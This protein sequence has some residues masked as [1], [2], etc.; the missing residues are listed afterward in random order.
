MAKDRFCNNMEGIVTAKGERAKYLGPGRDNR[1]INSDF[2]YLHLKTYQQ[3][4]DKFQE[5][6]PRVQDLMRGFAKGFNHS[7]SQNEHYAG[8]CE[9]LVQD[10]DHIDVFAQTL[11]IN[12]WAFMAHY[13]QYIGSA[14]PTSSVSAKALTTQQKTIKPQIKGSNGWALGKAMTETGK[15][16]ILSNTHLEHGGKNAWY[17]AH[18]TIPGEM[19]VYGG[20][21]PGFMTPALGFND[22]F[23]WTHTWTKA[24]PGSLYELT[25]SPHS[26]LAYVYGDDFRVLEF[27]EYQIDVKQADGSITPLSR[28]LYR[29]HYGPIATFEDGMIAVKDAPSQKHNYSDYWLKLALSKNVDE[30]VDLNRQGYRTGSQNIMMADSRGETFYADLASVPNLSAEAW[31]LIAKT[32]ELDA[33]NGGRLNG[34]DPVFEWSDVV[35]FDEVPKGRSEHYV[36]NANEAAWLMNLQQPLTGYS[37]LYGGSEYLQSPRTRL[38]VAMLEELKNSGKKVTLQDLQYAMDHK[39]IYQAELVLDDLVARCQAYPNVLV[40]DINVDLAPACEVLAKWD[41]TANLNSVGMH[42]FREYAFQVAI[43]GFYFGCT[44]WCWET[45]FD[46]K[47]PVETPSGLPPVVDVDQDFHLIS[48]ARAVLITA[49]LGLDV[50][51]PVSDVQYLIKGDRKHPIAGG[52]GDISGSFS[53]MAVVGDENIDYLSQ[54]GLTQAGYGIDNGD[55]FIYVSEF[56][57]DGINAR[58][59]LLYSQ[60]NNPASK[61][62]FDQ[63]ELIEGGKYKPVLFK[64]KDITADNNY[65]METLE[66]K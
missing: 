12:Y 25:P 53:T 19:D 14:E 10:I 24:N 31:S 17:E 15:G 51:S 48:L 6:D 32:P 1:N 22:H 45:T 2:A 52:Y 39:R 60:S 42:I 13:I 26:N 35:P 47:K 21:L 30:A 61:H 3:A 33:E 49:Q 4:K 38:S 8:G 57:S 18:L 9:D 55:G 44:D 36:Q 59:V 41:K 5:L 16:M 54:S 7:V 34:S 63:A 43:F 11:S 66:I 23:S 37:R 65:R 50:D 27:G 28:T 29:S 20:F 40:E 58:S 64:H 62:Y 56:T 46:P